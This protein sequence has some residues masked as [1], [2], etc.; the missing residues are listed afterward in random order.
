MGRIDKLVIKI[1]SGQSDHNIKFNELCK[2]L[3]RFG[4][5]Q[6]IKGSHHIFYMNGVNEIIN[7]QEINKKAKPYQVKQIRELILLYKF[8]ITEDDEV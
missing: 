8:K 4:F 6:R 2:L 1:L 3:L 5:S 7:I